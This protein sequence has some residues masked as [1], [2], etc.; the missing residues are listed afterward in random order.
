MTILSAVKDQLGI[1]EEDT[2]FDSEIKMDINLGLNTLTQLG[3]GRKE[4]FMIKT[5]EETLEDFIGSDD[6]RFNMVLNYLGITTKIL[7]D[8]S[9]M[10]SYV[11]ETYKEKALEIESRLSY[12]VDPIETFDE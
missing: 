2:A 10:S 4:G 8:N 7:F 3:V 11:L 5:G 12:Q 9:Q 6:P 1:T